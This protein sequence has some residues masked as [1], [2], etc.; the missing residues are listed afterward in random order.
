MG[1]W[2]TDILSRTRWS[3]PIVS[4]STMRFLQYF[5]NK[6]RP[7]SYPR[8]RRGRGSVVL[9]FDPRVLSSI[10]YFADH[11]AFQPPMTFSPQCNIVRAYCTVHFFASCKRYIPVPSFSRVW[12]GRNRKVR[13]K[14]DSF[15]GT[16][17]RT[18]KNIIQYSTV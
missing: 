8:T 1:S 2:E 13:G 10:L 12:D 17:G 14:Q 9:S 3:S 5:G 15:P 16:P 18:R 11:S 6:R 7:V 4:Y